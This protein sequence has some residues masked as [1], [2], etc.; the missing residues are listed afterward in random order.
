[1]GLPQGID[2][3]IKYYS[4]ECNELRR[5]LPLRTPLQVRSIEGL[6][7]AIHLVLCILTAY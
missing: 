7:Q 6:F 3:F 2:V 4:T 5:S 1:L